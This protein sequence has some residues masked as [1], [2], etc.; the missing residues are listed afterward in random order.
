MTPHHRVSVPRLRDYEFGQCGFLAKPWP[1]LFIDPPTGCKTCHIS[2]G[3]PWSLQVCHRAPLVPIHLVPLQV[4][5]Y[6]DHFTVEHEHTGLA[7]PLRQAQGGAW[8]VGHKALVQ[9]ELGQGTPALLPQMSRQLSAARL[10][11]CTERAIFGAGLVRGI[12]KEGRHGQRA[13]VV[14]CVHVCMYVCDRPSVGVCA[15][16]WC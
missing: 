16:A 7:K 5:H 10:G 9:H 2:V 12:K 15:W 3:M 4:L 13:C 1:I 8:E 6:L 11:S 14:W